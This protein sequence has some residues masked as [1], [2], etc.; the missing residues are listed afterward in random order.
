MKGI[1]LIPSE[2][3]K[4]PLFFFFFFLQGKF[5]ACQLIF[6]LYGSKKTSQNVKYDL[7]R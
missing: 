6:H 5:E 7:G 3:P 2:G 4:E 1:E